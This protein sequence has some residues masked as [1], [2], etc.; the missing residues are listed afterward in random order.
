MFGD[1]GQKLTKCLLSRFEL[2][3]ICLWDGSGELERLQVSFGRLL[4]GMLI[5]WED[6]K[7]R[8]LPG[9]SET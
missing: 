8:L 6:V 5:A 7:V 1:Q 3:L 4:S 2:R 9:G